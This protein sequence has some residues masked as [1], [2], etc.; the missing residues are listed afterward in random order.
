MIRTRLAALI[1]LVLAIAFV[2]AAD[3]PQWRGPNRDGISKETGLIKEWPKE[4]PELLLQGTDLGDGYSTTAIAGGRLDVLNNKGNDNE[5]VQ[6][7]D[8]KD[9]K[10]IWSTRVGKVGNP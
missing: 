5:L 6:A 8:V 3:W 4:G 10:E 7:R 2:S 9:G 1:F